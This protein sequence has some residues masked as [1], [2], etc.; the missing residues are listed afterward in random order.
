LIAAAC[1]AM[2]QLV[3]TRRQQPDDDDSQ[4]YLKERAGQR[5]TSRLATLP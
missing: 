2:P 5:G 1:I 3:R 4:A